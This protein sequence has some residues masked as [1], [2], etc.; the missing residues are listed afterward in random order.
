MSNL[1]KRTD[2]LTVTNKLTIPVGGVLEVAGNTIDGTE[3]GALDVV[4]GTAT[5]S[6]AVVLDASKGIATI[7]SAT[8]TTLTSTTANVPT[9]N[10]TNV[11]AGAS[12]TAGSVDVFPATAAKGKLAITCTDQ[13]GNTTVSLVAGA[14]AAARTI[15]VPDPG[16]A[17]S[18]LMTTGTATA[19]SATT[20]EISQLAGTTA[21]TAVASKALVVDANKDIVSL[22]NVSGVNFDAG[23]SGT[24]GSVDVFPTTAAKGK[25][26]LTCTDQAGDTAVSLV[27]GAMAAARTITL[28]DPLG[29]A[30]ILTDIGIGGSQTA[31]VST[32]FDAVTGT[33]GATLTNVVGAVLTVVPGT[34]RFKVNVS[35]VST[36]NSGMK[37]GLKYTTTV[38][39]SIESAAVGHTA[40]SLVAQ[41]STTATDAA[42]LLGSTTAIILATLEGTM[43]VTTGGT[44]QLQAAQNAAHADTT[45]VYVGSFMT[46]ARI[47]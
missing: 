11:D 24:A 7:T 19:T 28:A 18:V 37:L 5:A 35:G 38:L 16:A 26:A 31:K 13:T 36:V 15:T 23:A 32:Q 40:S 34:Y 30:N 45:S 3:F 4:P 6:K 39:S 46:L 43:V 9:V 21:G 44:I 27:I 47:A 33:T 41:H 29:T 22:R 8:I 2:R 17:A 42:T 10:S 12:G 14:M 1:W 20:T 25:L